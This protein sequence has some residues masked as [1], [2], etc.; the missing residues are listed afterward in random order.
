MGIIYPKSSQKVDVSYLITRF[1]TLHL[2]K[3]DVLYYQRM[4]DFMVPNLQI[5]REK[6]SEMTVVR[7]RWHLSAPGEMLKPDRVYTG[8]V[9]SGCRTGKRVQC[10]F[11]LNRAKLLSCERLWVHSAL[12]GL[13]PLIFTGPTP[14][15]C[16]GCVCG[17]EGVWVCEG[18]V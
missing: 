6:H 13:S 8:H 11:R 10:K 17:F 7:S 3:T 1:Y 9:L 2:A 14:D 4:L 16:E 5:L 18:C 15:G 12:L